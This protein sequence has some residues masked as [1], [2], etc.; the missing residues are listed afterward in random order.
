MTITTTPTTA[1]TGISH[2]GREFIP[3]VYLLQPRIVTSRSGP[4]PFGARLRGM[5]P[6]VDQLATTW[7]SISNLCASLRPEQW[8]VATGCPGWTVRDQVSHLIDYE[9]TALGRPRPEQD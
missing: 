8:E 3:T 6:L 1:A 7:R 9:A 5:L 4:G 2:F